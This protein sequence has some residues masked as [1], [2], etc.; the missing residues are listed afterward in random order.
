[1]KTKLKL[2]LSVL[3]MMSAFVYASGD[4]DPDNTSIVAEPAIV[5][6]AIKKSTITIALRDNNDKLIHNAK[7]NVVPSLSN[8]K[9]SKVREGF[10]D[11]KFDIEYDND[12]E[13]DRVNTISITA[14]GIELHPI[15]VIF[16]METK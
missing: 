3:L 15:D 4:I 8:T 6:Y 13:V 2:I 10:F 5:D 7:I 11:Y 16:K 14:D 1:M 9:T 12:G